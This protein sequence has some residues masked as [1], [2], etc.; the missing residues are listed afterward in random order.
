M[1]GES[2]GENIDNK[3][4][5]LKDPNFRV[6]KYIHPV[7]L[8]DSDINKTLRYISDQGVSEYNDSVMT[9]QRGNNSVVS[10]GGAVLSEDNLFYNAVRIVVS[11]KRASA[12]ILQSKLKI[13][14]ARA[15]RL[16]Y[17]LESNGVVG[18]QD[19]S[20]PREVLIDDADNFLSE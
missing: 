19:G 15:A 3:S 18:P 12:S 13:G 8:T 11:A 6:L 17:E 14:Y 9:P 20:K 10:E 16:I 4:I 1:V 5:I 2:G 7:E